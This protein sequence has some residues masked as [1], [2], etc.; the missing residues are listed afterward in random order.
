VNLYD[1]DGDKDD[2]DD[3]DDR[4]DAHYNVSEDDD[5]D[6]KD[7]YDNDDDDRCTSLES[8]RSMK[9]NR[10]LLNM[11]LSASIFETVNESLNQYK[12]KQSSLY[13]FIF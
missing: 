2:D 3:R 1:D 4:D 12:Y 6:D 11:K 13:V 10:G 5:K 8:N 9:L 7:Y